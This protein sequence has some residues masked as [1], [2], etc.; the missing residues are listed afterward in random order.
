VEHHRHRAGTP[1][2]RPAPDSA[3]QPTFSTF[4]PFRVA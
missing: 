2:N 4:R 1:P 3:V